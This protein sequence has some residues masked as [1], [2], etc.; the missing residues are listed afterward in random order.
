MKITLFALVV[1]VAIASISCSPD[2]AHHKGGHHHPISVN[3]TRHPA[4]GKPHLP[5]LPPHRPPHH[6]PSR[7]PRPTTTAPGAEAPSTA[8]AEQTTQEASENSTSD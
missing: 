5:H 2:P 4:H 6:R 3:G 8:Q 7:R 1:M